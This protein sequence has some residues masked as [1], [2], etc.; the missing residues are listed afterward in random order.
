MTEGAPFSAFSFTAS[1]RA[2]RV[3]S[4]LREPDALELAEDDGGE[5]N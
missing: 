3:L 1:T 4:P 2:V 5:Q